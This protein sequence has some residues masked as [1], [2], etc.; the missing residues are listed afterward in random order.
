VA[1][2]DGFVWVWLFM[3]VWVVV[4]G[5]FAWMCLRYGAD[6]TAVF[7]SAQRTV[8]IE[9]RHLTGT[10]TTIVPFGEIASVGLTRHPDEYGGS[11]Y[12][13][14]MHG[15]DGSHHMLSTLMGNLEDSNAVLAKI[16]A[17]TGLPRKDREASL[18]DTFNAFKKLFQRKE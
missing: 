17:E 5:F 8:C 13:L 4:S 10:G 2:A 14:E 12:L 3:V 18:T 16:E 11:S 6:I 9:H 1:A 7:D 15:K